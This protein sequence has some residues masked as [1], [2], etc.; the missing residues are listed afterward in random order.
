MG[1]CF[2]L[3]RLR[4][5]K[6]SGNEEH[7]PLSTLK[8]LRL[9]SLCGL[10]SL[11]HTKQSL[12]SLQNLTV[13]EIIECGPLRYLFPHSI[14]QSLQQL[15]FLK[16]KECRLLER[17]V[18]KAEEGEPMDCAQ[19]VGF[20]NLKVVQ[21]EGCRNLTSLLS[22]TNMRSLQQLNK[23]TII[24]CELLVEIISHVQEG[25]GRDDDEILLPKVNS[26][27]VRDMPGLKRL[28]SE[29]FSL[30]L[31]ALKDLVVD[32]ALQF[33]MVHCF[34]GQNDRNCLRTV[35]LF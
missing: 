31:P 20:P 8:R 26:F 10:W 25:E 29:S 27:E 12:A 23:I 18:A 30:N 6:S 13:V 14:A 11:W 7:L 19:S 1:F 24:K 3:P 34:D 15:E 17:I 21:V 5:E 4:T 35:K 2:F 16:I 32:G 28:C 22:V 33:D 9:V